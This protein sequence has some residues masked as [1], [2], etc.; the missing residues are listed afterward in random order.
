MQSYWI[1]ER[2]NPQFAR[3][4]YQTYGQLPTRTAL[5]LE[6]TKYGTNIMLEFE[7]LE[8]YNQKIAE[9]KNAGF[10]VHENT[11]S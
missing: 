10:T 8:A 11:V 3:P 4:Y 9:L 1:K 5:R 6:N 2:H 7:T